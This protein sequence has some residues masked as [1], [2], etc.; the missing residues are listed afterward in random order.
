MR[1]FLTIIAG[2]AA[3]GFVAKYCKDQGYDKD[4]HRIMRSKPLKPI[5]EVLEAVD[6]EIKKGDMFTAETIKE[7]DFNNVVL[8]NYEDEPTTEETSLKVKFEREFNQLKEVPF[9]LEWNNRTGYLD[10]AVYDDLGL[11]EGEMVATKCPLTFRKAI[12]I[13]TGK[14]NAIYFERYMPARGPY[15]IVH[16][17]PRGISI[18]SSWS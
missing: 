8:V 6:A 1:A 3:L 5:A 7:F 10:H 17:A 11:K 15:E 14:R 13:G 2:L 12:I 9:K 4:Y 16:N 18:S